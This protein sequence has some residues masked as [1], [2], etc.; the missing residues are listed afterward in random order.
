MVINPYG[1]VYPE[2]DLSTLKSL[3][4]IFDYVRNGGIY[5]NIADIPFYYAYERNL[6]RRIDTTPLAGDFLQVRSFLQ[7]ILTRKLHCFVFGLTAG[8]DFDTGIWRVIELT[9]NTNNFFHKEIVISEDGKKYSPFLAI[10]YGRGYFVFSTLMI[11]KE[12]I[13]HISEIIK[14]SLELLV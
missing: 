5:V 6:K 8:K 9:D 11:N 3:D 4:N 1:G 7:T 2:D 12:N 10:P 13:G 14:K